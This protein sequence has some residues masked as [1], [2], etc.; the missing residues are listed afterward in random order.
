VDTNRMTGTARNLAG[1][2]EE[3][4]GR[5]TG[6]DRHRVQGAVNQAAGAVEDAYGRASDMAQDTTRRFVDQ[7]RERPITALVTA[8]AVGY[9][10]AWMMRR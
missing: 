1:K 7:M 5:F 2:A 8:A 10:L 6:D 3:A 4:Y 9:V